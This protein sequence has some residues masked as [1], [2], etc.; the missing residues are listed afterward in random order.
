MI[1]PGDIIVSHPRWGEGDRVCF[2]TEHTQYSTVALQINNPSSMTFRELAMTK[3]YD[4]VED[5]PVYRGGDYNRSALIML[6]DSDWYSSNTM[7]VTHNWSISSDYHMLEKVVM[8][9]TP[10]YYRYVMG[11]TAW[12]PNAL[13]ANLKSSRPGWL[14]LSDP[15]PDLVVAD[16][17]KQYK[18]ALEAVSMNF[19]NQY[20]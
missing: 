8:G 6:H 3:G 17:E 20:L 2:I 19:W 14:V 10:T 7:A 13:E 9:N 5:R 11:I 4:C 12:A 16:P 15:D 18:L 1:G